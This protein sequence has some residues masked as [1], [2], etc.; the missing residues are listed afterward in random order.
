MQKLYADCLN[1]AEWLPAASR[2]RPDFARVSRGE[3]VHVAIADDGQMIGLVAVWTLE[4]FIHHL[5]VAPGQRGRGTGRLLLASLQAWLL[6]PWRLKCVRHNH[7]AL[8]FYGKLGWSEVGAGMSE[9]GEYLVLEWSGPAPASVP[10]Q[11]RSVRS[12]AV[13]L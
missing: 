13:R 12:G 10:D 7:E 6:P 11:A 8:A 9:D 2:T 4:N 1:G 3:V 5:Y